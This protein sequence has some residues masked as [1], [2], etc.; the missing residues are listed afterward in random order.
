[1]GG[2]DAEVTDGSAPAADRAPQWGF[3]GKWENATW[4]CLARTGFCVREYVGNY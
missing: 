4:S 1:M 2:V 3:V